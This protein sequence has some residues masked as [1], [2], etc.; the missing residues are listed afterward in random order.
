MNEQT[1]KTLLTNW[2]AY[3]PEHEGDYQTCGYCWHA[4]IRRDKAR[5]YLARHDYDIP[6]FE[7]E[8]QAKWRTCS[9][10]KEVQALK[11]QGFDLDEIEEYMNKRGIMI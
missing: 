4:I 1:A 7:S 3:Q 11:L 5:E 9:I 2:A 10:Y 6:K 8:V